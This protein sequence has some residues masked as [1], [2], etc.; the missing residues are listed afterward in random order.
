MAE[1]NMEPWYAVNKVLLPVKG[2]Y[3]TFLAAIGDLLPFIPVYMKQ[4]GLSSTEAGIIYGVMPFISFFTRPLFGAI[5]DKT[6]RHKAVL[7]CCSLMTGLLYGL[8]LVTPEKSH[9]HDWK[10]SVLTHLECNPQDSYIS[11]CDFVSSDNKSQPHMKDLCQLSLSKFTSHE[12]FNQ[13]TSNVPCKAECSLSFVT[14]MNLRMCFTNETGSYDADTCNVF[15]NNSETNPDV[16][17][18]IDDITQVIKNQVI[19]QSRAYNGQVC[20]NFDLK[21]VTYSGQTF[22]QATCSRDAVFDCFIKC[23]EKYHHDCISVTTKLSKT[24]WIFFIIFLFCN[25]FFAP[26]VSLIDAIAYDTLGEKRGRWGRQRM[27]GTVGFAI[28]A[29]ASTFIM[30]M[31]S[32]RNPDQ[33]VDYSVSFY[34]FVGLC[35]IT[36]IMAYLLKVSE[37]LQCRQMFQN[38]TK[39]FCYPEIVVFMLVMTFFGIFNSVTEAFLFWYLQDLGSSQVTLGLCLVSNCFCEMIMLFCAGKII[40]LIGH[41]PCLYIALFAW[42]VRFLSYSFLTNAWYVLP[43]EL[44]HGVC[45]GLM[46]G[47]ASAYASIISPKGMSATVQGLIGGL[48][49]GFGKGIGSLVTGKLFDP[50]S[51]LGEVWTFRLYSFLALFVLLVYAAVNLLFFRHRQNPAELHSDKGEKQSDVDNSTAGE[52]LLSGNTVSN[53]QTDL[54]L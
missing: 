26:V 17:F 13:N 6:R 30:D 2:I 34:I 31:L 49:F 43:V 27:W 24:F 19:G 44:L 9:P 15:W 50:V 41:I 4:L 52:L 7:I 12:P 54:E 5:A 20:R 46:Y 32:K 18:T 45:F 53:E 21:N 16:T 51:G 14:S 29:I 39:L 11:D 47:A 42:F 33:N 37:S 22:W 35:I 23:G 3:F 25:I 1:N 38:I 28:F 36:A 10:Y 8:L 40:K 48:Y